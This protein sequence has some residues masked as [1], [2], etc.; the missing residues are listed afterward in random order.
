MTDEY[1]SY[2][3]YLMAYDYAQ[4]VLKKRGEKG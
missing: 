1:I 4:V 2:T 3:C